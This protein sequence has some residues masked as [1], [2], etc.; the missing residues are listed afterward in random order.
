MTPAAISG[1]GRPLPP[2]PLP[3]LTLKPSALA[4]ARN[5]LSAESVSPCG[6]GSLRGSMP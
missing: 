4:S 3:P 5:A 2:P 1:S 6:V